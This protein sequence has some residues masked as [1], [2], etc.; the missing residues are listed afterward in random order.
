MTNLNDTAR[1]HV[2]RLVGELYPGSRGYGL[3]QLRAIFEAIR[4]EARELAPKLAG[5]PL[6]A[7]GIA[8]A[9]K[10]ASEAYIR[11]LPLVERHR[12]I[13]L[14]Q[15]GFRSPSM[16]GPQDPDLWPN[17]YV[18]ER[19][20]VYSAPPKV[21]VFFDCRRFPEPATGA[22]TMSRTVTPRPGPDDPASR[23]LWLASEAYEDAWFP[24]PEQQDDRC[25]E[26]VGH[27][28]EQ[29]NRRSRPTVSLTPG[30]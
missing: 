22:Y 26:F 5:T 29:R 15:A 1:A 2:A 9:P 24:T 21:G 8:R 7:A 30:S 17:P 23:L 12:I 11:L 16:V 19:N 13:R 14:G 6:T 18:F 10:A 28:K 3:E 4:D 20:D 25:L 27:L